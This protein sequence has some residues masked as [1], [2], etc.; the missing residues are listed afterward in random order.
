MCDYFSRLDWKTLLD[1]KNV[2]YMYAVFIEQYNRAYEAYVPIKADKTRSRQAPWLT[3]AL[4]KAIRKKNQL[5][6]A[7]RSTGFKHIDTASKYK[8]LKK[9]VA[10]DVKTAIKVFEKDLSIKAH[11]KYVSRKMKGK[12][13]KNFIH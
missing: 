11:N 6:F 7:N 2:N 12:S 4:K 1:Q 5:W 8:A 13:S 3:K 10:K 9:K